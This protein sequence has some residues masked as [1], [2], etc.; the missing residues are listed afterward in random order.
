MLAPKVNNA[1]DPT[2]DTTL[3]SCL[4]KAVQGR[5]NLVHASSDVLLADGVCKSQMTFARG[6]K[7]TPGGTQHA[8][9]QQ[10]HGD[11]FG[12][13]PRDIDFREDL[14]GPFGA[15]TLHPGHGVQA[16]HDE[17]ASLLEFSRHDRWVIV[18]F[19]HRF[20]DGVLHGVVGTG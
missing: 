11:F 9:P 4:L 20:E 1:R 14:N 16:V 5:L 19:L 7:R 18:G 12:G 8:I 6:A 15:V 10:F 2:T 3:A 13:H 17:V